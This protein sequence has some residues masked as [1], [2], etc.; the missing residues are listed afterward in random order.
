MTLR[1]P[2]LAAALL[3]VAATA[4]KKDETCPIGTARCGSSCIDPLTD[5][6][7]CG[8]CGVACASGRICCSGACADLQTDP[9]HCGGCGTPCFVGAPCTGGVCGPCPNDLPD[10]CP[11]TGPPG[12]CVNLATGVG[13]YCGTC[14]LAC[15]GT[16]VAAADAICTSGTCVCSGA[17]TDCGGNPVC[18]DLQT[19]R[20][21]CGACNV[22]CTGA[23]RTCS[24]GA[25]VCATGY[26]DCSGACVNTATDG[27]NCGGCGNHCAT[28]ATCTAGACACPAG[29]SVCGAGAGVC[30]N[31]STDE[32]NCGTCGNVC[33]TGATCTAGA[34]ACPAG[35]STTCGGTCCAGTGCCSSGSQCQTVHSN[36]LGQS[37]YDCNPL[38]TYTAAAALEAAAAWNPSGAPASGLSCASQYCLGWQA[39][40]ACAVWCYG[41]DILGGHV[42]LNT[43][44]IACICPIDSSPTWN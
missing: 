9:F 42:N 10:E 20:S 23:N 15:A 36:G 18:V 40:N 3:A 6:A 8:N 41:Q 21:S 12:T 25:C 16:G 37:Y 35:Q 44:S 11:P 14:G 26:T 33:P 28:G 24:G 31:R 13:G 43:I 17:A 39:S 5:P 29:D 27:S 38:G 19:D 1:G 22:P 2:A 30:V 34:C 7:N 4:C 32:S